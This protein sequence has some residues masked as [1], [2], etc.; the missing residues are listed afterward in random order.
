MSIHRLPKL[1]S[2][3]IFDHTSIFALASVATILAAAY[4]CSFALLPLQYLLHLY[5]QT[6]CHVHTRNVFHAHDS[7]KCL[8]PWG[9]EAPAR[10][11]LRRLHHCETM[12]RV[13]KGGPTMGR[14]RPVDRQPRAN[15]SFCY[16]PSGVICVSFVA[17][18]AVYQGV[19]LDGGCR[20][21]RALWRF[22]DL[23]ARVA[24]RITAS[25]HFEFFDLVGLFGPLQS[26]MDLLPPLDTV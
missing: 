13:R 26:V 11:F 10:V 23:F 6:Q 7:G 16:G 14:F 2:R 17:Q 1:E 15:H 25:R 12:A 22:H 21:R 5:A 18:A 8:L 19:I 9:F 24:L 4:I 3:P 20:G